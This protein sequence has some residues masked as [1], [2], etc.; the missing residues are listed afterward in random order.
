MTA[1]WESKFSTPLKYIGGYI[2][3]TLPLTIYAPTH[4]TCILDTNG[5][6]NPWI[7]ENDLKKSG[8]IILDR[9]L[10]NLE[11]DFR[12]SCP[13]LQENYKIEPQEYH[14]KVKN[15][16]GQEREYRF[17]YPVIPPMLVDE[18]EVLEPVY[19]QDCFPRTLKNSGV[20][21]ECFEKINFGDESACTKSE[22]KKVKEYYKKGQDKDPLNNGLGNFCAED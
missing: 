9:E 4:P 10:L 21:K 22:I 2:E 20:T 15:A 1:I 17:Y 18:D 14:F 7:N 12:K 11:I 6:K 13:Y 5:Y 19:T 8:L 3:W 16:F